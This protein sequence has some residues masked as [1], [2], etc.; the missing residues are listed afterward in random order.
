MDTIRLWARNGD[1]VRQAIELGARVHLDTASEE[2]TDTFLLFVIES[3]LLSQ[4]AE[5][6]PDPRGAPEIGMEVIVASHLAARFAG[7][8]SM[9]TSGYVLRSA[10]VLGALGSSGDVLE[11]AQGV[12]LRGTADDKR[13]SGEVW[14]TLLVQLE[15]HVDLKAPVR[16]PPVEPRQPVKGRKR[17]SRRAVKGAL[18]AGEA[19]ARAQRAAATLMAWDN[20]H[21]GPS[22]LPYAQGGTGRRIP[23]VDTTQVEVCLATGTYEVSGVPGDGNVRGEWCSETRRRQPRT[24]GHIGHRADRVGPCWADHS[25]GPLPDSRA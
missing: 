24:R 5:G 8:Y 11:P 2:V 9:R 7:L 18:N 25:R 13:I 17:A 6:F 4:W 23:I 12:S 10:A 14:R 3:G 1:A 20:D 22:L 19:E 21:V 15:N 16:V